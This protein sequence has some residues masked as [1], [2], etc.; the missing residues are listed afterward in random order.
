MGAE[1]ETAMPDFEPLRSA[2]RSVRVRRTLYSA[3]SLRTALGL[4]RCR[5]AVGPASLGLRVEL[6]A[7][8]LGDPVQPALVDDHAGRAGLAELG[9]IVR[10]QTSA[11]TV[12]AAHFPPPRDT[13]SSRPAKSRPSKR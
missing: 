11:I 13:F 5:R 3:E 1:A 6:F 7:I 12:P 10:E 8:I 9:A 2:L 4:R